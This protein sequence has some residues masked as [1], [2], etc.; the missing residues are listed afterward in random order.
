MD[1]NLTVSRSHST[2]RTICG[3]QWIPALNTGGTPQRDPQPRNL[4]EMATANGSVRCVAVASAE[5]LL[6]VQLDR[7]VEKTKAF[8]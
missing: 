3:S 1:Q 8:R 2:H 4:I 5:W 7:P 6:P